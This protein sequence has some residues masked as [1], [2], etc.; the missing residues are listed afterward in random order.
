MYKLTVA[1]GKVMKD[2]FKIARS[3]IVFIITVVIIY[4]ILGNISS[5]ND[6][7]FKVSRFRNFVVLTG[8][9][10]P[11][12]SPGD[13]ITIRKVDKDKLEVNDI[14]TYK[15]NDV[16]VTHQIVKIDGDNVTTQGT[17]NNVADNPISKD[18]ILGKYVFKIPKIGY[19]M[20]FITSTPGYILII[21][22]I[23]IAIFWE[24]S[25]PEKGKKLV[26]EKAS[27]ENIKYSDEEYAEFLEFK[28]KREEYQPITVVPE[29]TIQDDNKYLNE[30]AVVMEKRISRSER[31]KLRK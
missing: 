30:E 22:I 31:N 11:G 8:S 5:T 14:V 29:L 20:A 15:V 28:K 10:E 19:I 26:E 24:I 7:I 16:V 1:E 17:A 13:Y 2:I 4:G 12:I 3:I 21:G 25:D 6:S 18:D 23:A 9:M 27:S